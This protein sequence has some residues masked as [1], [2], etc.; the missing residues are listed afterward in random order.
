MKIN[1]NYTDNL[2]LY[3]IPSLFFLFF[4]FRRHQTMQSLPMLIL[5]AALPGEKGRE[6]R[7]EEVKVYLT[8][9]N[10]LKPY[11]HKYPKAWF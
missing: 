10:H 8:L 9:E 11:S 2:K 1:M 4:F 5:P 6:D 7:A 3:N